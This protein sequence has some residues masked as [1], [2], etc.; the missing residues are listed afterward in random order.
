MPEKIKFNEQKSTEAASLLLHLKGGRTDYWWIIKMLYLVDRE[1][2]RRW[3]RPITN[4]FYESLPYGPVGMSVYNI[5]KKNIPSPFWKSFIVTLPNESEVMLNGTPAPI[6]KLSKVE[7]DLITSVFKEF[8]S[9]DG[10]QL[11]EY[12]HTL[13]EWKDPKKTGSTSPINITDLL[14][15]LDYTPEEIGRIEFELKQEEILNTVLGE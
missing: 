10:N 5:I 4:D 15:V 2:F 3:E 9:L 11:V 1:A 6:K 7:V 14:Q 13:P 8:G 12:T